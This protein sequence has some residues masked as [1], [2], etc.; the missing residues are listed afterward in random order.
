M[1]QF[2][3]KIQLGNEAMQIPNDVG[4]ALVKIGEEL[5]YGSTVDSEFNRNEKVIIQDLNGNTVGSWMVK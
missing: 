2:I 5:I 1:A 3:L 4:E